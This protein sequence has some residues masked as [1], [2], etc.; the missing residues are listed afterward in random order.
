LH[1]EFNQKN[2]TVGF[3]ILLN[4]NES[5]EPE[6]GCQL[7]DK[8]AVLFMMHID[9]HHRHLDQVAARIPKHDPA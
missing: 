8:L 2:F 9:A 6:Y 7:P 4:C 3:G 1:D 5:T